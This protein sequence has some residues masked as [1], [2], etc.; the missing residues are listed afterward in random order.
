MVGDLEG[1]RDRG[2]GQPDAQGARARAAARPTPAPGCW[3]ASSRCT[4]VA[5]RRWCRDTAVARWS[6]PPSSSTDGDDPRLVRRLERVSVRRTPTDLL[7]LLEPSTRATRPPPVTLG[8]DDIAFLT[9][10]SGTTG[11]PKGAMN[12]HGNVVF[13]AQAYRDWIGLGGDDVVLGV[14]PL[15]HITGLIGHIAVCL[16]VGGAAGARV[17][18]RPARHAR[19]RRRRAQATFTVGAITVFIALMN[20]PERRPGRPA[21]PSPRSTAAARRSR[22]RPSRRF[23]DASGPYIHNIYG[24]TETTS[25]SH[26]VPFGAAR[27]GGRRRRARCRSASRS[28]TPIV[29]ILDDDGQDLPARARS[30]RS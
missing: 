24:L 27:A 16:L 22:R 5:A 7:E 10:T 29:R 18:V 14:A 21:P 4:E 9:Y 6:P 13:N 1:R 15:F 11:P 19:D 8:A 12:T 30:A 26:A 23:E 25:P 2:L 17:P 20:A 3:S 28:S